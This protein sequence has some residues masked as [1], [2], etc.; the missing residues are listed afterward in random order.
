MRMSMVSPPAK[1][2]RFRVDLRSLFVLTFCLAIGFTIGG[3][4]DTE[5]DD[6]FTFLGITRA[7][8][9]WHFAML[10]AASTSIAIGLVQQARAVWIKRKSLDSVNGEIR[11]GL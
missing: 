3:A 9:N 5:S 10:A 7:Q 11:F 8:L 1:R 2:S 6:N 4:P